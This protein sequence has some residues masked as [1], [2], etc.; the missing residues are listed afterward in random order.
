MSFISTTQELSV[1]RIDLQAPTLMGQPWANPG[2]DP[3][4]VKYLNNR[5]LMIGPSITNFKCDNE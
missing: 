1:Y 2:Q 3:L 4:P 5:L